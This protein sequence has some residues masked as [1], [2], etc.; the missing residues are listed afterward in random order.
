M[1]NLKFELTMLM[2][3]FAVIDLQASCLPWLCT[4]QAM[5]EPMYENIPPHKAYKCLHMWSL[6]GDV[7]GVQY[8]LSCGS[9]VNG[10]ESNKRPL[11][12][13]AK[14]NHIEVMRILLEH[15]A[16]ITLSNGQGS[17]ALMAAARCDRLQAVQFLLQA[18]ASV[19]LY[20]HHGYA[21][22]EY[23]ALS[24]NFEMVH[25]MLNAKPD[26]VCVQD[27]VD[28]LE[29]MRSNEKDDSHQR[30]VQ[31]SAEIMEKLRNY[32]QNGFDLK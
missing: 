6:F 20:D 21:D 28:R 9:N 25:D 12:L 7:Q 10:I 3:S 32:D 14:E 11:L 17:T 29:S 4:T 30:A 22:I 16:D 13:A 19:G 31:I 15:G 18:G 1:K 5:L 26:A 24:N 2:I 8:A 23:A 27:V